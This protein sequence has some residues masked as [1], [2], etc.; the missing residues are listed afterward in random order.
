VVEPVDAKVNVVGDTIRLVF[1]VPTAVV[2]K[3]QL[4]LKPLK[5]EAE[6]GEVPPDQET[7]AVT[8]VVWPESMPAGDSGARPATRTGLKVS[9]D[10]VDNTVAG[11]AELSFTDIQ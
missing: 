11:V 2:S 1:G 6:K 4:E 8:T 9:A 5:S 3:A 7:V 10:V